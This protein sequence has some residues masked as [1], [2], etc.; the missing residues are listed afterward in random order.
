MFVRGDGTAVGGRS[1]PVS[2][3]A[4]FLGEL[5]MWHPRASTHTAEHCV[6]NNTGEIAL[7]I[8][9]SCNIFYMVLFSTA[10]QKYEVLSH[11]EFLLINIIVIISHGSVFIENIVSR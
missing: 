2:C 8:V 7:L 1:L 4:A 5:V 3:K 11:E 6:V 9:C 10:F